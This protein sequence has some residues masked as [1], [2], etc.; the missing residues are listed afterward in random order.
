MA[1]AVIEKINKSNP[2][3][4]GYAAADY[5]VIDG[6]IQDS[7]NVAGHIG[8]TD[9]MTKSGFIRAFT[10]NMV[11]VV[12]LSFLGW[13]FPVLAFPAMFLGLGIALVGAFKPNFTPVLGPLYAAVEG[14]A[15][16]AISKFYE[17]QYSGIILQALILTLTIL[18]VVTFLYQIEV[19][20]VSDKFVK[21]TM[22]ATIGIAIYYGINFIM[23]L[24]SKSLPL[25]WDSGIFGIIFSLVVTAI[26]VSNFLVDLKMVDNAV[27]NRAP[28]YFESA[29]AFGMT[30]SVVWVYLEI[31]RLLSKLRD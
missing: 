8:G 26:A 9:T 2:N 28:K 10:I 4:A 21:F 27:E 19:I 5:S 24:F 1:N 30:I 20:K 7:T 12:A 11:L 22:F 18:A 16:G 15:V 13:K 17:A 31:L 25:I 6:Q 29:L 14:I 3:S 23:S